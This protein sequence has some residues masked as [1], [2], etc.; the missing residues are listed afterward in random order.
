ML[1]PS[2]GVQLD[3]TRPLRVGIIADDGVVSPL[4]PVRDVMNRV[5]DRL[6]GAPGVH[7]VPFS[8]FEHDKAWTIVAANYFEDGGSTVEAIMKEGEEPPLPLTKWILEQ[9]KAA[10]KT[11]AKTPEG[12]KAARDA[13][14]AAYSKHWNSSQVDVVVAPV[15]PCTAGKLGHTRYWGYSAVWNLLQYPAVALPAAALV[16]YPTLDALN[17]MRSGP[18]NEIEAHYQ[19]GYSAELSKDM[20]VGVQ[21]VAKHLHDTLLLQAT[22]IIED[23]LSSGS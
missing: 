21:V 2:L 9:C 18:K 22:E 12:I 8:P 7:L 15:Y 10:R 4:P 19:A 14:K 16:G 13:F 23:V 1:S 3:E 11:V 6:S 5:Y 20:P 17:Q